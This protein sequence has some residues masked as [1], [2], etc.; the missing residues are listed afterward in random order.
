VAL[1]AGGVRGIGLAVARRLAAEGARVHVTWRG[2]AQRARALEPEFGPR[3]HR[4]DLEDPAATADLVRDV[5]ALDGGLDQVCS[6]VGAYFA[7]SLEATDGP[8]LDAL[9]RSN[10][11]TAM[12]LV[13]AVRGPLRAGGGSLLL[14]GCAGLAGLRARR[15]CA[16]Y[17]AAKSA[18]LVLV[19]S[20]AVEEAP[21]G[22]RVNMLSPGLVPHD[23]AHPTTLDPALQ[24]AIPQG[25]PGTLEEAA[26]AARFL[27][28]AEAGHVTGTDLV[29]AGGWM[30]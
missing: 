20:L 18:L 19:R 24:A 29:L 22:V 9:W 6:T 1:V 25:R 7:G 30:L 15:D 3:L 10:V 23:G 5:V 11:V 27:L 12:N 21:H 4:V 26:A 13:T 17:A 2:S 28:S 16:A 8:T 14:L